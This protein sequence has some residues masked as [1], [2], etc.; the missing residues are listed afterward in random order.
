VAVQFRAFFPERK[1]LGG[2]ANVDLV[3]TIARQLRRNGVTQ[4]QIRVTI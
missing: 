3:E 1:D 4:S 2:R